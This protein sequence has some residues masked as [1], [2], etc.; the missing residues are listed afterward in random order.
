MDPAMWWGGRGCEPG[1]FLGQVL[2]A[3]LPR[4]PVPTRLATMPRAPNPAALL[5]LSLEGKR[6]PTCSAPGS[7]LGPSVTTLPSIQGGIEGQR[8]GGLCQAQLWAL[9]DLACA[10]SGLGGVPGHHGPG[11]SDLGPPRAPGA[12]S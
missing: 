2:P 10:S 4:A 6:V 8:S 12:S 11:P 9:A 7:P 3:S 1:V 5:L